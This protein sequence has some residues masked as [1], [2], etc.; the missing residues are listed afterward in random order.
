MMWFLGRVSG[1]HVIGAWREVWS[2]LSPSQEG[3]GLG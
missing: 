1:I 2:T 3:R